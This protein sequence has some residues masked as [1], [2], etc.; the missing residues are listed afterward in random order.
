MVLDLCQSYHAPTVLVYGGGY[1]REQGKT[2]WLHAQTVLTAAELF[3][4]KAFNF[5]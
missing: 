3:Q 2:G 1:N 5:F 4:A